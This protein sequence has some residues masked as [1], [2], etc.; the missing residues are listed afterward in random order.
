[1]DERIGS[2]P[3]FGESFYRHYS[4]NG[5]YVLRGEEGNFVLVRNKNRL[6]S[7]LS[8]LT[9]PQIG[10]FVLSLELYREKLDEITNDPIGHK[11]RA[12]NATELTKSLL[13]EI[14]S[15]LFNP[16]CSHILTE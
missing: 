10:A 4:G 1:M 13:L 2:L 16:D 3:S 7:F 6:E 11:T 8:D 9:K 5:E 12:I 15:E 14:Y